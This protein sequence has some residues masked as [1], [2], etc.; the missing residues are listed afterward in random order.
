MNFPI[1]HRTIETPN[2]TV[3]VR[4]TYFD[5]FIVRYSSKRKLGWSAVARTRGFAD[6]ETHSLT[7]AIAKARKV[8][9]S[10]SI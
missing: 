7:A 6:Y 8:A 2:Y 4:E 10:L 3:E 9:A 1:I 5:R